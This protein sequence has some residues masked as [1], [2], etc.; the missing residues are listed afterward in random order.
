[1]K[2]RLKCLGRKWEDLFISFLKKIFMYL[3]GFIW[4]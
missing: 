4:S 3:F 2:F 1:M